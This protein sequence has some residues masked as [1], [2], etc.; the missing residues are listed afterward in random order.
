MLQ[1][2][3]GGQDNNPDSK[4]HGVNMEPTWVLSAPGGPH[5]GLINLAIW[6]IRLESALNTNFPQSLSSIHTPFGWEIILKYCA[7]DDN[8]TVLPNRLSHN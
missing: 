8:K 4:V 7:E 2:R 1:S 3:G 5:V 6:V